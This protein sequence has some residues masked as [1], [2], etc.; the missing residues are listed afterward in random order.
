MAAFGE[1]WADAL[2]RDTDRAIRLAQESYPPAALAKAREKRALVIALTPDPDG[3][4][5]H[6]TPDDPAKRH[7]C[8]HC[9]QTAPSG[10]LTTEYPRP[11]KVI[12]GKIDHATLEA[13]PSRTEERPA[14]RPL[15]PEEILREN[16][17]DLRCVSEASCEAEHR[18]RVDAA[19]KAREAAGKAYEQAWRGQSWQRMGVP[20]GYQGHQIPAEPAW[21]TSMRDEADSYL[22]GAT[23]CGHAMIAFA[24]VQ[25]EVDDLVGLA[26]PQAD[27][28]D[29][30]PPQAPAPAFTYNPWSH[31]LRNN[32]QH[33]IGHQLQ[34]RLGGSAA[35]VLAARAAQAAREPVIPAGGGQAA[36][37]ATG[38]KPNPAPRQR[39]GKPRRSRGYQRLIVAQQ[40]NARRGHQDQQP[41]SNRT[42][43]GNKPGGY[44]GEGG[45][46]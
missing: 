1:F 19:R 39:R 24:R 18:R 3:P 23:A 46:G 31:V 6:I 2:S 37:N 4:E 32:R 16:P 15:F 11:P 25:S 21:L 5:P 42:T 20:K 7:A 27:E 9:G 28:D 45:S 38:P 40:Y 34:N 13:E 35:D 26:R 29:T 44:G 36:G 17:A 14:P 43:P 10:G 22:N 30:T 41:A 8:A 33:T 12:A